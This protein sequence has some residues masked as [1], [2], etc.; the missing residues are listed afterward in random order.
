[1]PREI[2]L[3]VLPPLNVAR[4]MVVGD[5]ADAHQRLL[6]R[7]DLV[8]QFREPE[9]PRGGQVETHGTHDTPWWQVITPG[10]TQVPVTVVNKVGPG[11]VDLVGGYSIPGRR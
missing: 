7:P 3:D 2:L 11:L 9:A 10:Y 4:G 5:D 1:M 8:V 6:G